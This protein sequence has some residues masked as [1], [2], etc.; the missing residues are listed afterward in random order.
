MVLKIIKNV[1]VIFIIDF[2]KNSQKQLNKGLEISCC[3]TIN[4]IT[5]IMYK[6]N[7]IKMEKVLLPITPLLGASELIVSTIINNR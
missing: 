3:C 1:L 4:Y 7:I 5:F 6:K 2:I